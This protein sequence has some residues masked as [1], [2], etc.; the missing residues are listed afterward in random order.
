[1]DGT[2]F[3]AVA[4]ADHHC[5]PNVQVPKPSARFASSRAH[6]K[7]PRS[8]MIQA[9]FFALR[10][11]PGLR[12]DARNS[13]WNARWKRAR[14]IDIEANGPERRNPID[15]RA[16]QCQQSSFSKW[17]QPI[18]RIGTLRVDR[19]HRLARLSRCGG[20][21]RRAPK[22]TTSHRLSVYGPI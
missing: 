20:F 7:I 2:G 1:M 16:T 3:A 17:R 13:S 9:S 18:V 8:Q 11:R 4:R 6:I 21:Q 14:S 22:I 12:H 19:E 5:R 15:S 10:R